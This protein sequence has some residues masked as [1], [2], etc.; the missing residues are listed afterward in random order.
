M[1]IAYSLYKAQ[2]LQ[3]TGDVGMITNRKILL[4]ITQVSMVLKNAY[5]QLLH[6]QGS[7]NTK[8]IPSC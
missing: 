1:Y 2:D 6:I 4:F 8:L 3:V 5:L 7:G